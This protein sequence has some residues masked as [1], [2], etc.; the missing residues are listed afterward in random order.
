[1]SRRPF[2][3]LYKILLEFAVKYDSKMWMWGSK[4]RRTEMAEMR[5]VIRH[6]AEHT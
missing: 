5:I 1:M 6:L 4:E 3:K 2:L